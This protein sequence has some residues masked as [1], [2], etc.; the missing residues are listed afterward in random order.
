MLSVFSDRAMAD[1]DPG[2]PECPERLA[3]TLDALAMRAGVTIHA[4]T[5]ATAEEL[6]RVHDAHYV[7]RLL[8]SAGTPQVLDADTRTSEGSIEAARLAAGAARDAVLAAVDGPHST[9]AVVRPPGHH[10][11]RARAMGFCLFNNVVVAAAAAR[12]ERGVQRILF[13][14][15]DVHHGNG[16]Q[17]LVAGTRTACSS[18][19]MRALGNTPARG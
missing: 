12:A 11:C 13:V 17:D 16:T 8:A 14:D 1:H 15:W 3:A 2:Q 4:A 7:E 5:P 9:F 10:A 6:Q 19:C 18:A